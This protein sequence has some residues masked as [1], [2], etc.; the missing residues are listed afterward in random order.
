MV[1]SSYERGRLDGEKLLSQQLLEQRT[2]LQ[3]LF[4]GALAALQQAVPQV[5]RDTEQ[6]MVSLAFEIARK[7]VADLPISVEMVEAS[8]REALAQMEGAAEC[9]VRL[10]PEDLDLLR[11]AASPLLQS[12]AGNRVRFQ[13]SPDVTRGGCLVHTRFGVI[14][15]RR[16]T[17]LDLLKQSLTP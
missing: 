14:D 5:V 4:Q 3:R 10:H 12:E 7:L 2:E 16:E 17:K 13:A 8:V 9:E 15:A 1:K 11:K 6:M